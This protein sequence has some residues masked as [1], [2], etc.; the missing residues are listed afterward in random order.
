[1]DAIALL[2]A[3]GAA[4][5]DVWAL[6]PQGLEEL[7][8][9]GGLVAIAV[10]VG[11]VASAS[12]TLGHA[13]VFVVNHITGLRLVLCMGLGAIYLLF[14]HLVSGLLVALVA[15]VVLGEGVSPTT[16]VVAYLLALAPQALGVL[17]FIPWL[18]LGIGRLLDGWGLLCRVVVLAALLDI[19]RWQAA[20]VAGVAWLLT[21]VLS[22]VLARPLASAASR[23][24]TLATGRPAFLTS[25]DILAGTP[26]VPLSARER[27]TR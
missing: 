26:F 9:P 5:L 16:I 22:R 14:L 6:R 27:V 11:L 20:L 23:G 10:G 3:V 21:Q 18:G 25:H 13:V 24:W 19:T 7:A 12:T 8:A 4:I 17:V 2:H 1:M 15:A